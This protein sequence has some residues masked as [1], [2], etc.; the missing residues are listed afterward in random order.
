M[1]EY[2]INTLCHYVFCKAN[3]NGDVEICVAGHNPPLIIRKSGIVPINAN[4]IPIGLFFESEYEP[5]NIKLQKD[6]SLLLYTDGLTEASVNEVEYGEERL[7][8][9]L[10][11]S[12]NL[13][14]P[15]MID[16]IL[17]DHKNFLKDSPQSDDITIAV[18][19]K[20]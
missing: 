18:I 16:E 8:T 5:V 17:I 1:R 15:K 20:I 3:Y 10:T 4:S 19:K 9:Q 12:S 2:F 14:A 7:K 13:A 11:K 6:D